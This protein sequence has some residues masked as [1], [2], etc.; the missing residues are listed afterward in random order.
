MKAERRHELQQNELADWLAQKFV[1]VRPYV[2]TIVAS[3]VGVA[4]LWVGWSWYS[5]STATAKTEVWNQYYKALEAAGRR[6]Q[7]P[8]LDF[9]KAHP[10]EPV[11]IAARQRLALIQMEN[12]ANL[13]LTNRAASLTAYQEAI[14]NFKQVRAA[15]D[16]ETLKRFASYQIA[17]ALESRY[18]LDEA[19]AEYREIREK[20]PGSMEAEQADLRIKD[21]SNP[22]TRAFYEWHRTVDPLATT[23]AAPSVPV[24]PSEDLSTLPDEPP[25]ET[26][27]PPAE[28]STPEEP[29][30]PA[31]LDQPPADT[32]ETPA[33]TDEQPKDGDKPAA[34][35]PS[36]EQPAEEKP[37]DEKPAEGE[38]AEESP[39]AEPANP[40]TGDL[41]AP[42]S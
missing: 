22:A 27:T 7:Q 32:S 35:K 16:D 36:E 38:P 34:A 21:L 33:D 39:S 14:D 1:A 18:E 19:V 24:E 12:A 2:M 11:G 10:D 4:V 31:P 23:P 17:L 29:K 20:W 30:A 40:S 5:R 9:V 41:N 3:L 25:S 13:Q 6:E 37:T 28:E 15:T 8:L 26:T 42:Q